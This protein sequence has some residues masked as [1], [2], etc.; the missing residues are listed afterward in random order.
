MRQ[1]R[2]VC[3]RKDLLRDG[4]VLF[5]SGLFLWKEAKCFFPVVL[6]KDFFTIYGDPGSADHSNWHCHMV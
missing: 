2:A 1:Q 3:T 4:G 5:W 6:S